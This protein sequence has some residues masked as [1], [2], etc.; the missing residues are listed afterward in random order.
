MRAIVEE[1]DE[2]G[3]R[4]ARQSLCQH[5]GVDAQFLESDSP[6]LRMLPT[7]VQVLGPDLVSEKFWLN[8]QEL[9]AKQVKENGKVEALK[10]ANQNLIPM[11]MLL[12]KVIL[13]ID[14]AHWIESSNILVSEPYISR[15][16][17]SVLDCFKVLTEPTLISKI[18]DDNCWDVSL[19]LDWLIQETKSGSIPGEVHV[20]ATSKNAATAMFLPDIYTQSQQTEVMKFIADNGFIAQDRA[21]RYGLSIPNIAALA[22]ES[23]DDAHI[24]GDVLMVGH[25]L[26]Q[27][28][29]LAVQVCMANGIVDVLDHLPAELIRPI[30]LQ[31][32]LRRVAFSSEQGVLI[33]SDGQ[34]VLVATS[35]VENVSSR[36]LPPL[37]QDFA[38]AR[39]EEMVASVVNTD[40]D[41]DTDEISTANRSIKGKSRSR[42]GRANRT[43][44]KHVDVIGVVPLLQVAQAII[45]QFPS[46]SMTDI[47]KE[48]LALLAEE[49]PWGDEED[50]GIILVEFCKTALHT[51]RFHSQCEKATEAEIRRLKSAKQS[52]ATLSRKDEAAKVRSVEMAFEESFINLCYMVQANTKFLAYAE[53]SNVVDGPALEAL[54]SEMLLCCCAGLTS[55][56]T[57]YCLFK[58]EEET[59]FTF[60]TEEEKGTDE[61]IDNLFSSLPSFCATVDVAARRYRRSYL[62]CPPPREPLRVLRESLP[63]N[64]GVALARQWALCGGESYRGGVQ[65]SEDG[66]TYIRPGSIDGFLSHMQENCLSLCGLPFKNLDKKAEKQFLFKRRQALTGILAAATE[67]TVILELTIMILFQQVKHI[68]VSGDFLRNGILKML[69]EERKITDA[70]VAVLEALDTAI[71]EGGSIS[72]DL[73]NAVRACALCRDIAKHEVGLLV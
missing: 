6:L 33:L 68:V 63:G 48:H 7:S 8:L 3:G 39:A 26:A 72:E 65:E 53:H 29:Q 56:I 66:S 61:A 5:L 12:G 60:M 4:L 64:L 57:Q 51:D 45:D 35:W 55:R 31:E 11:E 42:K 37:V 54:R 15:V 25:I 67:P 17:S 59:I 62:S 27:K 43:N 16:R 47:G 49:I 21:T 23:Y 41:D 14:E 30:I 24:M 71:T 50:S 40:V 52:K 22:E 36:V 19:S 70:V 69:R 10:L 18:C 34:A 32:L 2:Q 46:T 28:M 9:V 44:P 73:V 58:N 20:D 13:K 1:L 38:K